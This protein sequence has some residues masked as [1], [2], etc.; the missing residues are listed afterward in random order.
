M[1]PHPNSALEE[2][3]EIHLFTNGYARVFLNQKKTV[4]GNPAPSK[5]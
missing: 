2:G 5:G 4:L 1:D 3:A